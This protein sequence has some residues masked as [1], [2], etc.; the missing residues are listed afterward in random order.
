M[1][2]MR[3]PCRSIVDVAIV[4]AGPYGLSLAAHLR[5]LGVDFRI[6]GHPMHTWLTQMPRGMRLKSEG[7]A[8]SLYDPDS[9]LTLAHYCELKG[10]PYADAGVPVSLDTFVSYGLEFQRRFV[11][12]LE[13]K[14]VVSLQGIAGGFR[15]GFADGDVV[16]ARQVVVAVGISHFGYVPAELSALSEEFASHSSKH[17]V[18]DGFKGREVIVVGAGA[19]ALDLA[20]LLHQV[21]AS[22]QLLARKPSI[23]FHDPPGPRSRPL[24]ERIRLPMSGLGSGWRLLFI[25]HAPQ[26]FHLLPERI[27]LEVVRRTLGPAPAWFTKEPVVGKVPLHLGVHITQAAVQNGRVH[28]QITDS[29]GACRTLVCDHVIA[30]TGYRVDLR[31]LPFLDSSLRAHI[32]CVEQSPVLSSRFE[33][34]VPGLY[35]V[36]A[37]AANSFG[38]LLRFA[39]GAGFTAR[40]LSRHLERSAS[41]EYARSQS[42]PSV[43]ALEGSRSLDV[44]P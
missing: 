24:F 26:L 22:V 28:L 8:S 4:G 42:A 6:F 41:R 20:A 37:S 30:A 32:R 14:L 15:I 19:S 17:S 31:R 12:D 23:R 35:F 7:F 44:I 39:L 27:R 36:G 11:P 25:A 21:G 3:H 38:P 10:I 1:K 16:D 33:S 40:R 9:A 2:K 43:Q 34:S 13:R 29:A 5:A 18:L